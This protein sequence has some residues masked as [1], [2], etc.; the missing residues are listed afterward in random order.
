MNFEARTDKGEHL[1]DRF[2]KQAVWQMV[3]E[4]EKE[5]LMQVKENAADYQSLVQKLEVIIIEKVPQQGKRVH[6]GAVGHN[7]NLEGGSSWQSWG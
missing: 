6:I 4:R 3:P 5:M 1:P 7:D 2:K